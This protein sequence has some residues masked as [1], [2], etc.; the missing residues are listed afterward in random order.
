[1]IMIKIAC[2]AVLV[3]GLM[4]I[5]AWMETVGG[6]SSLADRFLTPLPLGV[7]GLLIALIEWNI[8]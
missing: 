5:G 2:D 7:T 3:A 4:G 1:M 6:M 8:A